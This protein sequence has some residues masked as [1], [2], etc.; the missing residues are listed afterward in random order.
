MKGRKKRTDRYL[1]VLSS[2][3]ESYKTLSLLYNCRTRLSAALLAR[4]PLARGATFLRS[5]TARS[6]LVSCA[7][8]CAASIVRLLLARVLARADRRTKDMFCMVR[9]GLSQVDKIRFVT[10]SSY[11]SALFRKSRLSFFV[12][13]SF[14]LDGMPVLG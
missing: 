10:V 6:W 4:K 14:F 12:V 11:M 5:A 2:R 13:G 1:S 8:G 7:L 3:R 9:G